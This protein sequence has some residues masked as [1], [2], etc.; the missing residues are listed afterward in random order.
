MVF[1][2]VCCAVPRGKKQQRDVSMCYSF[3]DNVVIFSVYLMGGDK[4]RQRCFGIRME[5][6]QGDDWL[7]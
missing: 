4:I 6:H 7:P 3:L 1:W 2:K 5:T